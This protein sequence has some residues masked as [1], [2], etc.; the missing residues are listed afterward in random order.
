MGKFKLLIYS[1]GLTLILAC[2]RQSNE[3]PENILIIPKLSLDDFNSIPKE[4]DGCACYFSETGQKFKNKEYL[5]A[6]GFDS[7]GFVSVNK[8]IVKLKLTS[9]A[10]KPNTFGDHDNTDI[11]NSEFYKVIVDIKYK[12]STGNET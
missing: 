11:Y 12:N 10:R 8:E 1:I 6:A 7:I 9:T 4:V 3:N 5:F 2:N